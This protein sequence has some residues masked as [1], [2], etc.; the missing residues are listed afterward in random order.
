MKETGS[1]QYFE[2]KAKTF[3]SLYE[4]DNPWKSFFNHWLRKAVYERHAITLAESEPIQGTTLLDV[5][6]GP[7][8]YMVGFLLRGALR[9][10]GIDE[11]EPML[12]LARDHF[13][14][15]GVSDRCQLVQANFYDWKSDEKFDRVIA[16]GF[17][18]YQADPLR[19]LKKMIGHSRGLVIGSFP[20][21][22]LIRMPLRRLRYE[23]RGC[24]IRFY[25]ESELREIAGQ[26]GFSSY[27]IIPI[28][29]SG[30]GFM[31]IG[32]V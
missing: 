8:R 19:A 11:A 4:D 26:A 27:R 3:D 10:V 28:H 21:R 23:L 17:F 31:L 12:A 2:K 14:K 22:S 29:T 32:K 15:A 6:C 18:D 13:E 1:K 30:S 5:G 24:P 16:I 20:G 25:R 9:A 7:G